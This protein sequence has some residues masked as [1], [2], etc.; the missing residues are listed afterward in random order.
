MTFPDS[1]GWDVP[2][3]E[4]HLDFDAVPQAGMLPGIQVF[5]FLDT[6]S[7]GGGGTCSRDDRT[8]RVERFMR[9]DAWVGGHP[10]QVVE[11][12]GQAGDVVLSRE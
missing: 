10:L 11:L 3:G 2:R 4:W 8:D 7:E 1:G 9:G 6:V 12:T 5:V